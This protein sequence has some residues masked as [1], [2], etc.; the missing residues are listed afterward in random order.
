MDVLGDVLDSVRLSGQVIC[1]L[2]LTAPWGISIAPV[3]GASFHVIDRGSCWIRLTGEDELVPLAGGDLVVFPRGSAHEIVDTP[4][5]PVRG[6]EDLTR[7]L[8]QDSLVLRHGGG[9]MPTTVVC[10]VLN[11]QDGGDH[12]LFSLLP[13]L[14]H[15]KGDQGQA[16]PWLDYTLRFMSSEAASSMPGAGTI[17]DR[18]SD[19][20]FVQAVRSW[21]GGQT[22][23][24]AGWLT[25]LGDP[26]VGD[27]LGHIHGDP[28]RRWTVDSLA[29]LVSMS[30]S[31][32]SARFSALVGQ[33]PLLYV[34]RWRMRLARG[35]LRDTGLRPRD[36][37]GRLGYR[38]EDPFKRA[39]KRE[40]GMAPGHY[41]RH[42][43]SHPDGTERPTAD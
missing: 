7:S 4:S 30:R 36:I 34:T 18:L 13:P 39:F 8:G 10:G 33:P 27:A 1:R 42:A 5:S 31:A 41:R 6:L 17:I 20:L 11:H 32:F 35:W 29:S 3:H 26:Q 22:E 37:A 40:V 25:A 24:S 21:I 9:G 15:I 38:S 2:E 12:A 14:I 28:G 16:S 43:R 23:P 19:I